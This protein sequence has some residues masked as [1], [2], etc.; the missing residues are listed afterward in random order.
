[1]SYTIQHAAVLITVPLI[2]L[3]SLSWCCQ[4]EGDRFCEYLLR[5][6]WKQHLTLNNIFT[7][8]ER[9][10]LVLSVRHCWLCDRKGIR[11]VKSWVLFCRWWRSDWSVARLIAPV[12]TITSIILNSNKIQ[13]AYILVP[14]NPGPPGKMAVKIEREWQTHSRVFFLVLS[15]T[16]CSRQSWLVSFSTL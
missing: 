16:V 7:Q 12:V 11:P 5:T 10:R 15:G 3:L 6:L 14:A 4:M 13:N 8:N 2:L 9:Q 1:M